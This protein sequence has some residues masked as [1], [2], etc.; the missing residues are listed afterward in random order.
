VT[1]AH[2]AGNDPTQLAIAIEV[3]VDR[4][5]AHGA[6]C[7]RP[8]GSRYPNGTT[9]RSRPWPVARDR[10]ADLLLATLAVTAGPQVIAVILSGAGH[11]GATG[12]TAVHDRGGVVIAA[13]ES[14]STH[15]AMPLA[16]TARDQIV[17]HVVPV[18]TIPAL[19]DRLVRSPQPLAAGDAR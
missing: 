4:V 15:P 7:T 19:L 8:R 3:G 2:R 9:R 6:G 14:L 5:A 11:D 17:G 12:A 10:S 1:V 13:D 16:A 18:D